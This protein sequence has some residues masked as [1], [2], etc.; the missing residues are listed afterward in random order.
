MALSVVI[1]ITW[2]CFLINF[3]SFFA[4]I[5]IFSYTAHYKYVEKSEML[6]LWIDFGCMRKD[7]LIEKKE[8]IL[9][10]KLKEILK[11][12]FWKLTICSHYIEHLFHSLFHFFLCLS[13]SFALALVTMKWATFDYRKKNQTRYILTW[14]STCTQYRKI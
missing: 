14:K 7:Y 3:I 8:R 2:N 5:T 1:G 11:C 4:F 10:G 9:R 12:Y 13:L 6:C